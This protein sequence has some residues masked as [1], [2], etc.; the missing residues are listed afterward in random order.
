MRRPMQSSRPFCCCR[1]LMKG[2]K[3]QIKMNR[4]EEKQKLKEEKSEEEDHRKI[5]KTGLEHVAT[6]ARVSFVNSS[7]S[8][9]SPT[10]DRPNSATSIGTSTGKS[11]LGGKSSIGRSVGNGTASKGSFTSQSSSKVNGIGGDKAK[12]DQATTKGSQKMSVTSSSTA[13]IKSSARM[14]KGGRT[15]A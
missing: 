1:R 5:L 7:R 8:T 14:A 6:A 2:V 13:L 3:E 4:A 10:G 15:E 9:P 12:D 11:T